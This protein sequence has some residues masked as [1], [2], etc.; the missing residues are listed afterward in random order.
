MR[1]A[2]AAILMVSMALSWLPRPVPAQD[3]A[4]V[5]LDQSQKARQA[6][7]ENDAAA[8]ERYYLNALAALETLRLH[9]RALLLR[10][11]AGTRLKLGRV[12][13]AREAAAA[14]LEDAEAAGGSELIGW[15]AYDLAG[16]DLALGAYEAAVTSAERAI[17]AAEKDRCLRIQRQQLLAK[18][19]LLARDIAAVMRLLEETRMEL[20]QLACIPA[21]GIEQDILEARAA[22]WLADLE[23][24][25]GILE[26]LQESDEVR[27]RSEAMASVT[28]NMAEVELLRGRFVEAELLT[29]EAS[30]LY[31]EVV[32]N[33]HIHAQ[34]DHRAAVIRQEIGDLPASDRLYRAAK[35]RFDAAFG[36]AHPDAIAVRRE[37]S[38]LLS[39][40]GDHDGAVAEARQ[41]LTLTVQSKGTPH[42]IALANAAL[43]L[44]LHAAG[45]DPNAAERHLEAAQAG[46]LAGRNMADRIPSL[47]ALS[48]IALARHDLDQADRYATEALRILD[49]GKSESVERIGRARRILAEI[50]LAQGAVADALELAEQNRDL[51]LERVRELSRIPSYA[52]EFQPEELRHQIAQY[53]E[54]VWRES[55]ARPS[56]DELDRMYQAIQLVHFTATAQ[57]TNGLTAASLT[58]DVTQRDLQRKMR[59]H[60]SAIR[61]LELAQRV[62]AVS[63]IEARKAIESNRKAFADLQAQLDASVSIAD[64]FA[65]TRTLGLEETQMLLDPGESLWLHAS[66]A[67]A[68]YLML[69][70]RDGVALTQSMLKD[71]DLSGLVETLR[72]SLTIGAN[73][74]PKA[75][76]FA[77]TEAYSLYCGLIGPFDPGACGG[78]GL[79]IRFEAETRTMGRGALDAGDHLL[80]VPDRAAEQVALGALLAAPVLGDIGYGTLRAARW[81]GVEH[82]LT[83]VPLV[84]ALA[85]R[86]R[87]G[88]RAEPD[89]PLVAFAPTFV[90]ECLAVDETAGGRRL[91]PLPET[92]VEIETLARE[93]DARKGIDWFSCREASEREVKHQDLRSVQ[94]L[95]FASHAEVA[96]EFSGFVEPGI[97]LAPPD[98]SDTT[99]NGY[100]TA[101]EIAALDIGAQMVVLSACSTAATSGLPGAPGLSGL[102]R[103][104]FEAG[105]KSLMVSHWN[106]GSKPTALLTRDVVHAMRADGKLAPSEALRQ[107]I[108][109]RLHDPNFTT[110]AHPALWAPFVI[111]GLS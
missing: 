29:E 13:P 44:A 9:N 10:E 97:F 48:E 82:A 75:T 16:I 81:L 62:G 79:A 46:L 102:A 72:R 4:S 94:I 55:G 65:R 107:A 111:V 53:L 71:R 19:K 74:I 34:I 106:V 95:L 66:L 85:N 56:V 51:V 103:A 38:V 27:S 35:A 49:E 39:R 78:E 101:S 12:G 91:D 99:D 11:I 63:V 18:I 93:S 83:T 64:E 8:A 57:A 96:G 31:R 37:R 1:V 60:M 59:R 50:K 76:D 21:R 28:Y 70:K 3:P 89:R 2:V 25:F 26:S 23:R 90:E 105:A 104:F 22:I 33:H 6:A 69:I 58:S 45:S 98:R 14:A 17:R 24:A 15:V 61:G 86:R 54:I 20:G 73:S 43:G 67:E 30:N 110:H 52:A 42:A 68:S 88:A 84:A 5:V 92:E 47:L 87:A 77:T 41:A 100:L 32:P 40:M 36:P 108:T 80:V 109:R 7:K